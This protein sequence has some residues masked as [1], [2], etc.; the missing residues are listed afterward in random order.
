MAL[1]SVPAEWSAIPGAGANVKIGS[2]WQ[3]SLQLPILVAPSVVKGGTVKPSTC[4]RSRMNRHEI[5]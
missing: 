1:A 3:I 5:E 4:E 2:A